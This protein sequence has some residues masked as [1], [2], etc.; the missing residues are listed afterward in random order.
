[1]KRESKMLTIESR[2]NGQIM[3]ISNTGLEMREEVV[4]SVECYRMGR[5]PPVMKFN[6]LHKREKGAEELTLRVY[7]KVR[8]EIKKYENSVKENRQ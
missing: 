7:Q 2:I 5:E 4:Y 1:L 8:Q 6:V 3:N